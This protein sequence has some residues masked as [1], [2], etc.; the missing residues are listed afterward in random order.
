MGLL[1]A[2]VHVLESVIWF[3][4]IITASSF[5]RRW[6]AGDRARRWIDRVTGGI[7]VGFGVALA[8]ESRA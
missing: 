2:L 1:L 3:A 6:L 4:A 5:A 7:L 8:V